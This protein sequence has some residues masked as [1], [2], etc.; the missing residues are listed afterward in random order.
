MPIADISFKTCARDGGVLSKV[1]ACAS[2]IP[3]TVVNNRTNI[4]K[5]R[6]IHFS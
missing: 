2:A 5:R 4:A 6:I 3:H 1:T